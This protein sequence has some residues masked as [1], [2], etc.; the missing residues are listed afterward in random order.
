L[1]GHVDGA[2]AA[3]HSGVGRAV[4]VDVERAFHES[5]CVAHLVTF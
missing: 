5:V 1:F 4:D 3:F 2:A